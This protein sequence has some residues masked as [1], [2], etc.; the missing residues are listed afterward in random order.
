M[1]DTPLDSAENRAK[2]KRLGQPKSALKP[3]SI[4]KSP[5]TAS[6]KVY[7]PMI[8]G[9]TPAKVEARPKWNSGGSQAFQEFD[10]AARYKNNYVQGNLMGQLEHRKSKI[11]EF[12]KSEVPEPRGE[13]VDQSALS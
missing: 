6:K 13:V 10:V 8:M 5:G 11:R 12:V 7:A 9:R 2:A 3:K 1:F 4:M